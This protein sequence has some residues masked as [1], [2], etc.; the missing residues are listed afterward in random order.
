MSHCSPAPG[1]TSVRCEI[2]VED[3]VPGDIVL[4]DAGDLV[5]AD[6]IVIEANAAQVNQAVLTG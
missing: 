3:I 4:L 2:P 5:P 1:E 6:G